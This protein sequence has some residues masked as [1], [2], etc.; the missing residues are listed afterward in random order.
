MSNY[1]CITFHTAACDD[2]FDRLLNVHG[3][4]GLDDVC[5]LCEIERLR[6]VVELVKKCS[7]TPILDTPWR[8]LQEALTALKTDDGR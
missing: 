4:E 7:I 1:D 2:H 5:P 6:A 8:E 3:P